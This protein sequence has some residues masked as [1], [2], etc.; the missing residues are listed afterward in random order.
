MPSGGLATG[1]IMSGAQAGLGILQGILGGNKRKKALAQLQKN[2]F[3][4]PASA[5]RAVEMQGKIAQGTQLPGQ[6]I[7]EERMAS[8]TANALSQAR[9]TATSPSQ[10]MQATVDGYIAQQQR[11]Q[12]LDLQ[13]AQN[14]QT[15]Q[16]GYAQ[17]V[18]SLAPY[19]V[20]KWKYQTLYPVQEQLN[21]AAGMEQAGWGN[22]G[23]GIQGGLTTM[24]NQQYLNSLN[25]SPTGMQGQMQQI[26]P[27][28]PQQLPYTAPS[29]QNLMFNS[30]MRVG[31][32]QAPQLP[33]SLDATTLAG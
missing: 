9:Q 33:Y 26:S 11:Q 14:Y 13:A 29:T 19:E 27:I 17:S 25:T 22:I 4:V 12:E 7:I 8:G 31:M 6:D 10:M 1:L 20:E 21:R 32:Q 5:R 2:P 18:S 23:A 28:Q 30:N 24:A 3:Q 16:Q 15:M